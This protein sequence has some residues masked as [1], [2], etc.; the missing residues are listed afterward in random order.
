MSRIPRSG[1]ALVGVAL[2]AL[3]LASGAPAHQTA[4]AASPGE[5][6]VSDYHAGLHEAMTTMM[7]AMHATPVSA[8]PDIDFLAMMIPHH[9]AAVEM[10]RLVLLHGRDP[11]VR[12][13]AEEIIVAQQVEIA[14]MRNRLAV[15]RAGGGPDAAASQALGGTRGSAAEAA[16]QNA[17]HEHHR[18]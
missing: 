8:D 2:L 14:S 1:S 11:L 3:A 17:H 10:A 18:D 13:L 5:Q 9:E 6:G 4:G 16:N 15:L 7:Q 12:Q